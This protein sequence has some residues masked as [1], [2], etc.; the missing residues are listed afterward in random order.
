MRERD[1]LGDPGVDGRII[2]RRIFR[3]CDVGYRLDRD[4][5]GQGQVAG[6][7]ECGTEPSGFMERG[8]FLD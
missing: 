3:K 4:D 8:G 1:H 6:T 2:L 7:Y 5:S